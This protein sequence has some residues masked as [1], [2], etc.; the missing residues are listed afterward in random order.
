VIAIKR[1]LP[2]IDGP[3]E[4]SS[5][6]IAAFIVNLNL[7]LPLIGQYDFSSDSGAPRFKY[8]IELPSEADPN[9]LS[10]AFSTMF[11][12]DVYVRNLAKEISDTEEALSS[13][14]MVIQALEGEAALIGVLLIL[15][16]TIIVSLTLRDREQEFGMYRSRGI[17][18]HQL[19]ILIFAQIL[20]LAVAGVVLGV[21]AGW[22][23]GF[24][25]TNLTFYYFNPTGVPI[26]N[27]FPL[28]GFLLIE[29]VLLAFI[30]VTIYG[31]YRLHKKPII[32]QIRMV[33]R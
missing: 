10:A 18:P 6:D 19:F 24:L 7:I 31:F 25:L 16:V 23:S 8:L 30:L 20:S 27:E 11:G 26:P 21:L 33:N 28:S 2:G 14:D 4:G 29:G 17:Q 13:L 15:C 9:A 32:D 3:E 22:V 12:T 1:L 5:S